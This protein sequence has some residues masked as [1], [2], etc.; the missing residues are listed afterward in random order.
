MV[1]SS[2]DDSPDVQ[3]PWCQG[4]HRTTDTFCAVFGLPMSDA[5]LAAPVP[6]QVKMAARR[7]KG[8]PRRE[9]EKFLTLWVR[10]VAAAVG[11]AKRVRV[12]GVEEEESAI[13]EQVVS[14]GPR[15]EVA[16]QL[17]LL[18]DGFVGCALVWRASD[19]HELDTEELSDLA[20]YLEHPA[21]NSGDWQFV[22]SSVPWTDWQ[23]GC[24]LSEVSDLL[25]GGT[26][27][28]ART[29]WNREGASPLD[30][31]H[32][33]ILEDLIDV[34]PSIL[35][36]PHIE[37]GAPVSV[38]LAAGEESEALLSVANN[39]PGQLRLRLPKLSS[40]SWIRDWPE[41]MQQVEPGQT[42]TVPVAIASEGPL[43]KDT[44]RIRPFSN[45]ANA[46]DLVWE[47]QV[48][49]GEPDAVSEPL[50]AREAGAG[51]VTEVS[52]A[53][54]EPPERVPPAPTQSVLGEPVVPSTATETQ[55]TRD[56][57]RPAVAVGRQWK[58]WVILVTVLWGIA[59]PL[60]A[61]YW[62]YVPPRDARSRRSAEVGQGAPGAVEPGG[63]QAGPAATE[64]AAPLGQPPS[65]AP[66]IAGDGGRPE[67]A[68]GRSRLDDQPSV[69]RTRA[70]VS[71]PRPSPPP[72]SP[73]TEPAT[74]TPSRRPV[75]VS[76]GVGLDYEWTAGFHYEEIPY[77]TTWLADVGRGPIE[78][79][80]VE[81]VGRAGL[82]RVHHRVQVDR[83]GAEVGERELTDREVVRIPV[84]QEVRR[85]F[86]SL[87]ELCPE[88]GMKAG[89][90]CPRPRR[91]MEYPPG[92]PIPAVCSLHNEVLVKVCSETGLLA[93]HFC[94]SPVMAEFPP[95]QAPTR[96][97]DRH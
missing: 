25:V 87:V 5:G 18:P 2:S 55:P 15:F 94:P 82:V 11:P 26:G 76:Q 4:H 48:S 52:T 95:G 66:V 68:P 40:S 61:L 51:P 69:A 23:S 91:K 21:I 75:R 49:V 80:V 9:S 96:M 83:S 38:G 85:V 35:A 50:A 17:A 70:D 79:V 77:E 37:V 43:E 22:Q 86:Y 29:Y 64:G 71:P 81:Q 58:W 59:L 30:R 41:D 28:A 32:H 34:L 72:R 74:P 53:E 67:R 84:N 24:R 19:G 90:N 89:E 20:L 1:N 88:S 78:K 62:L 60:G 8:V 57:T 46:D 12:I 39:G 6:R 97:C 54:T 13:V 47:L 63:Y 92:A 33:S 45:A 56:Y 36:V 93:S 16:F 7:V 3:C 42:L 10:R 73:S 14:P 27:V 44:T 31:A 65:R